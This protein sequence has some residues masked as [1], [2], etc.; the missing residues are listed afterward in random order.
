MESLNYVLLY[1]V[2]CFHCDALSQCEKEVTIELGLEAK[3]LYYYNEP[4]YERSLLCEW[5]FLAKNPRKQI[6]YRLTN[7]SVDC[8]DTLQA[9]TNDTQFTAPPIC[10]IGKE[11]ET[12]VTPAGELKL[13]LNSDKTVHVHEKGFT[14]HMIAASGNDICP[15]QPIHVTSVKQQIASPRFPNPYAANLQC[16]YILTAPSGVVLT[17]EYIDVEKHKRC[18]LSSCCDQIIIYEGLPSENKK[19]SSI[20]GSDMFYPNLTYESTGTTLTLELRTDNQG[21]KRGF[22]ATVQAVSTPWTRLI[23]PNRPATGTAFAASANSVQAIGTAFAASANSGPRTGTSFAASANS[24][25]PSGTSFAASANSGPRTGT[26]F[27][28]SANSVQP[29]GTS[30]AASANSGP[31]TGTSFAASANS[32]PGT[33]TSFAASANSG[34]GTGT[35]FAASANSV[36]PSGTSFAASANS[37]QASGTAFAASA[38]SV[39]ASGTAFAASANSVQASGTAF[40]ASANSV[41]A[42]GTAFA[43]SENSGPGTGTSFAASENSGPGT[44]TSFAASANSE[45]CQ[46]DPSAHCELFNSTVLCDPNGVFFAWARS[47][48]PDYCGLCPESCKDDPSAHCELYNATAL[49]DPNGV[50]YTWARSRCPDHCGLCPESCEDDPSAHCELYNAAALCD[51]NGVYY[52]WARSSCPGSCGLCRDTAV[53]FSST[54]GTTAGPS[55]H[56]TVCKDSKHCRLY[57]ASRICITNGIYYE[58]SQKHCPAYCGYCQ[59]IDDYFMVG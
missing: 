55:D 21:S 57:N 10:G 48:C 27:A 46:N 36:Q 42:S 7:I 35:S 58:W 17:F 5:R 4:T 24:V 11:S 28:A 29:S 25:Q 32:G 37:V 43:A 30:F 12:A 31:G 20:C 44:G 1:F 40:A 14:L 41:Q 34:P 50:Y 9:Y 52:T 56:T 38:N 13:C 54:A 16:R 19:I 47:R 23:T 53:A 59:G 18:P 33:G 49:C 51:P 6:V 39:Q 26:S 45:S 2:L 3:S 22:V 8:G 15:R